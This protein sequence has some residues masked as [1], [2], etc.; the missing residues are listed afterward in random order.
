MEQ[1]QVLHPQVSVQTI[2]LRSLIDRALNIREQQRQLIRTLRLQLSS[3]KPN[4]SSATPTG[5][6]VPHLEHI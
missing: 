1:V 6:P 3:L 2:K 5:Y 4:K